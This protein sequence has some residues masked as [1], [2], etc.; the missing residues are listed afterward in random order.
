MP[1]KQLGRSVMVATRT[2]IAG[3]KTTRDAVTF[4]GIVSRAPPPPGAVAVVV[5]T[6][7]AAKPSPPA[8]LACDDCARQLQATVAA[9]AHLRDRLYAAQC[10]AIQ[11]LQNHASLDQIC[12]EVCVAAALASSPS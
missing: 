6:N 12:G 1:P 8:I 7:V 10:R 4:Q 5:D 9:H 3:V 11:L 2:P